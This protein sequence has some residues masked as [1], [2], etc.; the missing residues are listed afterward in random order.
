MRLVAAWVQGEHFE[1]GILVRKAALMMGVAKESYLAGGIQKAFEGLGGSEDVFVLVLKR[2]MYQ[3]DSFSFEGAL[4]KAGEPVQ[5]FVG[6]LG[7]GPIYSGFGHGIKIVGGHELGDRLVVIAPD[8]YSAEF[9]DASGDFVGIWSIAD[10]IAEANQALPAS[11]HGIER[12]F[13]S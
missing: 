12:G 3:N 13:Q 6:E 5:I 8:C 7:A 10:D 2:A 11:L 1:F 9:A 4:W